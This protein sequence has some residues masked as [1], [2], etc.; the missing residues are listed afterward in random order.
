MDVNSQF[1]LP[2]SG[3]LSPWTG[4]RCWWLLRPWWS[5]WWWWVR[6]WWS[7]V[8]D[9]HWISESAGQG[10]VS[11]APSPAQPVS[12]S[13]YRVMLCCGPGC[14]CWYHHRRHNNS[15]GCSS[16]AGP[17]QTVSSIT[18][19][20]PLHTITHH[21]SFLGN[22]SIKLCQWILLFGFGTIF[23]LCTYSDL[24]DCRIVCIAHDTR[25]IEEKWIRF[26]IR[27]QQTLQCIVSLVI[28]V[29]HHKRVQ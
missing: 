21:Y 13:L 1:G 24:V 15:T 23:D 20:T 2:T 7:T 11:A 26:L 19:I 16:C 8:G 18:S 5:G 3:L 12:T 27:M 25:D 29:S 9:A 22:P 10:L 28:R 6:S 4:W 17:G 14:C